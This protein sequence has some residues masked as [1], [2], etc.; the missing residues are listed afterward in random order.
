MLVLAVACGTTA[1]EAPPA[2]APEPEAETNTPPRFP[3]WA[4]V[5]LLA[6]G[7]VVPGQAYVAEWTL[8]WPEASDD[9]LAAYVILLNGEEVARIEPD[10]EGFDLGEV[11]EEN[12]AYT[13]VAVDEGGLE[14]S[15][16]FDLPAT[17]DARMAL[18]RRPGPAPPGSLRNVGNAT[19]V[20]D[21]LREVDDVAMTGPLRSA[22]MTPP[23]ELGPGTMLDTVYE[24]PDVER[25]RGH[26]VIGPGN[27]PGIELD[28]QVTRMLRVR[29]ASF[30]RCYESVLRAEPN[31]AGSLRVR[32]TVTQRGSVAGASV[33]D[34]TTGSA[35]LEQCVV[36]GV[37]RLRFN[38]GPERDTVYEYPL[39]FSRASQ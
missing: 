18:T 12:R 22:S 5:R 15:L 13:I 31:V 20:E 32:F 29:S 14:D 27:L 16:D 7:E 38:P 35:N 21:V 36:N 25:A 3:D 28:A 17:L 9:D 26:V 6:T 34:D 11:P 8:T 30:R 37:R 33:E 39:E 2:E 19:M 1:P 24:R 10:R 23:S 4:A